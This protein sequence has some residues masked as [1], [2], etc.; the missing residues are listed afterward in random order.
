MARNPNI[1]RRLVSVTALMCL[2]SAGQTPEMATHDS[3]PTFTTR[4]NLVLVRVVVRDREGHVN[5]SLQ[6]EDFQL[7][8]KG[9]SQFISKFSLEKTAGRKTEAAAPGE[10]A[11]GQSPPGPAPPERYIAYVFD[12]V[13]LS[14]GD[15][16]QA[17]NAAEKHLSELAP[18]TRAAIYTTS[19]LVTLDFT[20]VVRS[21]ERRVGKE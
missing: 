16:A 10:G 1:L 3:E 21:E 17:R 6:K 4:S 19:G 2:G 5:G 14:F 8:D 15:L 18:T 9:K 12:D 13:H 7:F 11:S 20:D